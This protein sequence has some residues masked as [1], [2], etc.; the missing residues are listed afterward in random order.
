[1]FV[2]DSEHAKNIVSIVKMVKL[3]RTNGKRPLRDR[4]HIWDSEAVYTPK[5]CP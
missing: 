3:R 5:I 4:L 1:V 2:F